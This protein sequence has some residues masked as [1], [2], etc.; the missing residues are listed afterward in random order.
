MLERAGTLIAAADELLEPRPGLGSVRTRIRLV[1]PVGLPKRLQVGLI[2]HHRQAH[3]G[4]TLDTVEASDPLAHIADPFDLMFHFGPPPPHGDWFSRVVRRVPLQLFA[5]PSYLEHAGTPG[6]AEALADH[7]LL[8]WHAHP[9]A[10]EAWPL[11]SGGHLAIQPVFRSTNVLLLAALA[12]AGAGIVLAPADLAELEPLDGPL[13]PVL[14]DEVAAE[15]PF[16]V[17][18]PLPSCADPWTA[19]LLGVLQASLADLPRS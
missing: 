19:E 10:P 12:V 9:G 4:L 18:S 16:R 17:L 14:K 1:V 2:L 11:R 8:H 3:P 5:A 6:S 15:F 7:H 13:V